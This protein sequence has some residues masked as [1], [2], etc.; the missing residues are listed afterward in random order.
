MFTESFF[1][2]TERFHVF[3]FDLQSFLC[4]SFERLLL[5]FISLALRYPKNVGETIDNVIGCVFGRE[6]LTAVKVN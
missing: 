5:L 1:G 2:E 4:S 3:R 6:T